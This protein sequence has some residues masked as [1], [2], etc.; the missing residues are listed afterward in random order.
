MI[1]IKGID[2]AE[3]LVELYN[4]SRKQ[5]MGVFEPNVRISVDDARELLKKTK[6]FDYLYGK[7]MKVDLSKDDEFDEWLYDRDNG[8]GKAQSVVAKLKE[9][10]NDKKDVDVLD[11]VVSENTLLDSEVVNDNNDKINYIK[12]YKKLKEELLSKTESNNDKEKQRDIINLSDTY[13][14]V[15]EVDPTTED[16]GMNYKISL[17]VKDKRIDLNTKFDDSKPYNGIQYYKSIFNEDVV[18]LKTID[19]KDEIVNNGSVASNISNSSLWSGVGKSI[20]YRDDIIPGMPQV[21]GETSFVSPTDGYQLVEFSSVFPNV[22][23]RV[24]INEL[25]N[26]LSSY[27]EMCTG[28]GEVELRMSYYKNIYDLKK[29]LLEKKKNGTYQEFIADGENQITAKDLLEKGIDNINKN[30]KTY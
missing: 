8:E 7:V 13:I 9:K 26:C 12:D 25:I 29:E 2:K 5:G 28:L 18:A 24:S 19:G 22:R 16:I 14:G 27:V 17:F 15:Y 30:S 21:T 11:D 3:L 4:N 1:D 10:M 20:V 23:G 6:S